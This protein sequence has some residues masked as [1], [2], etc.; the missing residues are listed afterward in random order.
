MIKGIIFDL[1]GVLIH[2]DEMHYQAWKQ[3]AAS[4]GAAFDREKN[5]RLR[6]V[7]RMDCMDIILEGLPPMQ[8]EE[9]FALAEEKNAAYRKLLATLS[10]SDVDD[11]VIKVLKELRRRNI[12]LAIGSSSKNAA[13][14]L[15]KTGLTGYFDAISDG[16][17]IK[18]SKPDPEVFLK[19]ADMLLLTP[20]EC[21]VI[22]DAC[23]GIDAAV[24]GGFL[25]CGMGDA[26]AYC[27]TDIKLNK[28]SDVLELLK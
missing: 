19:A 5:N 21:A 2:T 18:R 17:N 22:E 12:K 4:I 7:A 24:A 27:K 1:D 16:N 6:G 20:G 15:E 25:S 14:I 9:K 13:F 11:E 28:F 10:Q 8:Y 23:A 26:A 3:I